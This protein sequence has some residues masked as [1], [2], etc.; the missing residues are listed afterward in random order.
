MRPHSRNGQDR[1]LQQPATTQLF[2]ANT[3][4]PYFLPFA[5]CG[6]LFLLSVIRVV[7]KQSRQKGLPCV[8]RGKHT[9]RQR[10]LIKN[11]Q[12]SVAENAKDTVSH[13]FLMSLVLNTVT[14][15]KTE[16]AIIGIQIITDR[17]IFCIVSCA[18]NKNRAGSMVGK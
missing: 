7:A 14:P 8:L 15:A 4:R 11:G 9:G 5:V 17:Q 1:S 2:R 6:R 10:Q 12:N 18:S 13:C 16:I 3:V